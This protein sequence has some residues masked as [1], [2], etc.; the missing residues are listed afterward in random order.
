MTDIATITSEQ[1]SKA[2]D[3][4]LKVMPDYAA[5]LDVNK[6]IFIAQEDSKKS[7]STEKILIPENVLKS[8]IQ[9]EFPLITIAE[10]K[11]DTTAAARLFREICLIIK[12][13]KSELSESA[14]HLI[15]VFDEDKIDFDPLYNAFLKEDESYFD[16][17]ASDLQV[18]KDI[19]SYFV[20][21]SARPSL[22]ICANELS[23]LL[24][25]N[26]EW[27]RG[28]C[29]ICGSPPAL[30]LFEEDGKRF[31]CCSFC[32]YKWRTRR[33]FCH[34]CENTDHET[35][36]YYSFED[37]EG[38]RIDVCDK[39]KKYIKT[40]DTRNLER[41]IYPPLEYLSTAHLDIKISEMGFEHTLES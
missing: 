14:E 39:C 32:W 15:K 27:H 8:K 18:D 11:I 3:E 26:K 29:P 33:I 21:N 22:N 2:V 24:D 35:L 9:E 19:L 12:N 16:T 5:V 7:T 13:D 28:Y 17:T 20:Y 25:K 41:F 38:Y 36:H 34:N 40:I 30:S 31:F 23:D 1:I 4:I 10:F 6:K 37:D